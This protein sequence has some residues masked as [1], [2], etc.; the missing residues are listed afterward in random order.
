MIK[1]QNL[2]AEN[3]RRFNTKNLSE[4]AQVAAPG[5]GQAFVDESYAKLKPGYNSIPNDPKS[6]LILGIQSNKDVVSFRNAH[7]LLSSDKTRG[8]IIG[9]QIIS[10]KQLVNTYAILQKTA[11]LQVVPQPVKLTFGIAL[12]HML[13]YIDSDAIAKGGKAWLAAAQVPMPTRMTSTADIVALIKII[14]KTNSK[15]LAKQFEVKK[16]GLMTAFNFTA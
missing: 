3:M 16:Q 13:T 14:D 11:S 9:T 10:D 12:E 4:Q 8:L 2:L 15:G 6:D 5:E 7:I 1:L